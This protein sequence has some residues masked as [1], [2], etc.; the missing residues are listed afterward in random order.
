MELKKNKKNMK[1]IAERIE[2]KDEIKTDFIP[3]ELGN[4][5]EETYEYKEV[6]IFDKDDVLLEAFRVGTDVETDEQFFNSTG[7]RLG[8]STWISED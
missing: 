3:D 4:P 7:V 5:T 8:L 6:L 1:R 2:I